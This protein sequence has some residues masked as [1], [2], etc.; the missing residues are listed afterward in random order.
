[1]MRALTG[2][3]AE[4]TNIDARSRSEGGNEDEKHRNSADLLYRLSQHLS[5]PETSTESA[6]AGLVQL[7]R[8]AAFYA[9][10]LTPAG[11]EDPPVAAGDRSATTAE[12]GAN[13][14][15][16]AARRAE[17]NQLPPGVGISHLQEAAT[18]FQSALETPPPL[19]DG[20]RSLL[21]TV[22]A[23]REAGPDRRTSILF[24]EGEPDRLRV[25]FRA[26]RIGNG[27]YFDEIVLKEKSPRT[28]RQVCET[29]AT[30]VDGSPPPPSGI[31]VVGDSLKRDI[32]PANAAGCTTVYCP[33]DLWGRENPEG[34][35]ERPDYVVERIDEMPSLF[36]L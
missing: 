26:Y 35:E 33:G 28:Y 3:A 5:P 11:L 34:P 1:M 17:S 30:F 15:R 36:G 21:N 29:I 13:R 20:A 9:S 27:N 25:A 14:I 32:R 2:D 19:L 6:N 22:R 10:D 31:V 8:A 4:E 16:W 12:S 24:S 23:W 7:A 18:A